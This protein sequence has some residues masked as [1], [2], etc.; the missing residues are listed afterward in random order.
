[1][2]GQIYRIDA[3]GQVQTVATLG[4]FTGGIVFSPRDQALYACYPCLGLVRVEADGRHSLFATGAE[5]HTMVYPNYPVFDGIG[6]LYVSDTGNWK[7]RDGY[8]LRLELDGRGRVIG[9]PFGYANVLAITADC[10]Y[11][12]MAESDTDRIVR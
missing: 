2:A 6:R 8:L 9:G 7:K 4:G 5:G 1:E 12:C 10:R 3:S 11:L